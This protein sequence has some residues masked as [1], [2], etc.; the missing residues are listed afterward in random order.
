V[1]HAV[2]CV[3]I[4]GA[5]QTAKKMEGAIREGELFDRWHCFCDWMHFQANAG[6]DGR[7]ICV[8]A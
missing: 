6:S 2:V 4:V 5:H 1:I 7:N 3:N 8:I